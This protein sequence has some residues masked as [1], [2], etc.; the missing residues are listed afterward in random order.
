VLTENLVL[1]KIEFLEGVFDG[2]DANE[3]DGFDADV[4]LATGEWQVLIPALGEARGGEMAM[5]G[6]AA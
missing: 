3:A 4:A 1:R 6:G 2:R 5:D